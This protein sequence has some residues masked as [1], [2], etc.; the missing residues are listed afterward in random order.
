MKDLFQSGRL[1]H[2]EVITWS[3]EAIVGSW[4]SAK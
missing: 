1:P 4:V 3:A 2:G